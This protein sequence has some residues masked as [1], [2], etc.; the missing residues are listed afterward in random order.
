MPRRA[1]RKLAILERIGRAPTGVRGQTARARVSRPQCYALAV[2]D[3]VNEFSWSRTRDNVFPGVP[4]TLLLPVLRRLGRLGRR[5]RSRSSAA[6]TS[7]S[8][9]RT[10]QMWAGRLVHEAIER[11][12]LA[13]RDGHGLSEASLIEDTVR[14][15]R[16]EWK[17][18]RAGVYRQAPKRPSPVRARVRRGHPR[19]RVAGPARSRGPLPAELPPAARGDRHQADPDRALGLHRGHRLL[20]VRGHAR[21]QRARLRLLEPRRP[22]AAPGLE[23]RGRRRGRRRS[24]SAATPSMPSRCWAWISVAVDLLEVNLR[25]GKVTAHPWDEASLDRVREH[26]RLSVRSMKAY[27]KDPALNLAE[28]S[29]FEKTEELRICRWCNF[30]GVCRPDLAPFVTLSPGGGE[31]RVRGCHEGPAHRSRRHAAR[32]LGRGGR[33]LAQR[34]RGARRARRYRPGRPRGLDRRDAALVLERPEPSPHASA[35]T[36]CAPGRGS[37]R[38]RSAGWAAR[39]RRWPAASRRTSPTAAGSA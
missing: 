14:Q 18:S 10:R 6:S 24:S 34:V 33:V 38:T 28:E 1:A 7:S 20:P 19:Q 27:L 37:P 2:A 31:G 39:T 4:P 30:R 25:E 36:C 22:T 12:L 21:V 11:S 5:L 17:G 26:I 3:L 13:L 29:G 16:E 35:P 8:S 15:M 32:L 23:D 9:S